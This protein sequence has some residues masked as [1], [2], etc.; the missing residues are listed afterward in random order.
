MR[1]VKYIAYVMANHRSK[2]MTVR[3]NIDRWLAKTV[4]NPANL[5]PKPKIK[6]VTFI[7]YEKKNAFTYWLVFV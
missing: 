4:R 6:Y 1:L 7:K 5:Q 2:V 3:V